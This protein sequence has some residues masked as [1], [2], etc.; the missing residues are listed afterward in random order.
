MID[1]N[2]QTRNY[3]YYNLTETFDELYIKSKNN[4]N[5]KQDLMKIITSK[6]NILSAYRN[7]K[8]NKG[9]KTCGIDGKNIDD[10][11][12][13]SEDDFVQKIQGM[14]LNHSPKAIRQVEIPK[15]N[16][17]TRTLGISTIEDRIVQQCI[18]QVIEPILEAKFHNHSYGFRPTRSTTHA[19]SRC[20]Y[21]I[22]ISKLHYVVDIDIKGFF[23]N[24]NH[25]KLLKILYKNNIKDKRVISIIRK[26]IK[27]EVIGKGTQEKGTPQGSILSPLLSNIYLNELDWWISNQWETYNT[28]YKYNHTADKYRSLRKRSKLKEMYI[29]RYADDF[30][31]FTKTYSEAIRIKMAVKEFL[32]INLKLDISEEKS[33]ITNLKKNKSE[34][35]GFEIKAVKKKNKFVA[36]TYISKKSKSNILNNYKNYLK[37]LS[38]NPKRNNVGKLNSYLMGIKNYYSIATMSYIDL[39]DIEYKIKFIKYNRLKRF[40][41]RVKPKD[42]ERIPITFSKFNSINFK[43]YMLDDYILH[44][45]TNHGYKVVQNYNQKTNI[46]NQEGRTYIRK[47]KGDVLS[48]IHK[49]VKYSQDIQRSTEYIDNRIAKYSM[50]KGLCPIT[51]LFLRAEDFH[52]HHIIPK[53]LGGTD[54]F[55][56]LVVVHK[57]IH[58]L[59]HA[60]N[61]E[62]INNIKAEL[63]LNVEQV[64]KVNLYRRN[65]NKNSLIN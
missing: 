15:G 43:T 3:A 45:L 59:I 21:L 12:D 42:L 56:N 55:K 9:S 36:R 38:K 63:K 41:K 54:E 52:C 6:E 20:Q 48:E 13:I 26:M 35:L 28:K 51:K 14:I 1:I 23:D 32:K 61:E 4:V 65:C 30:K 53:E 49:I 44:N 8:S 16:N 40:F 58:K 60:E 24:V 47:L 18:K 62:I 25:N 29:V 5:N 64:E 2:K 31:I 17:K 37:K 50:Q 22:N 46:F 33:K 34:F 10:L 27:C 7:I 39:T 57:D 11:K 19:I